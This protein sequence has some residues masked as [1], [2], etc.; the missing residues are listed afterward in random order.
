MRRLLG[1]ISLPFLLTSCNCQTRDD[2]MMQVIAM[3]ISHMIEVPRTDVV[4]RAAIDL[5]T[6]LANGD[7]RFQAV[8]GIAIGAEAL[9]EA[10]NQM[11]MRALT[12]PITIDAS[13]FTDRSSTTQPIVMKMQI[14]PKDYA[15]NYNRLLIHHLK[16]QHKIATQPA[17]TQSAQL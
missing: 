14:D 9:P 11:G 3:S 7:Q 6:A 10:V 4:Y 13:P 8:D 5:Q 12:E 1:L 2:K 16:V 15:R 17:T